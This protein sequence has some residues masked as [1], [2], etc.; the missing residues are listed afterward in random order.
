MY[1]AFRPLSKQVTVMERMNGKQLKEMLESGCNNLNNR[2]KEV[3]ALNVFPVPDGDTGTNMS[4]TFSNGISEILKSGSEELPVIAKTLSRGL[5]MGARGNSGVITSQIFRGFYQA[6]KELSDLGADDFCA[7]MK[8]GAKM[9]YK[10]VMRPVEGTILTVVREATDAADAYMK[11]HPSAPI[12]EYM[13]VL[14]KEAQKSLDHTPEL[15]PVLKE[16]GCVDSGGAGLVAI[17]NGF[18]SY[19]KGEPVKEAAEGIGSE[20]AEKKTG[21][22]TEYILKLTDQGTHL[23]KE[24]K[25]RDKLNAL[26]DH[27]TVVVDGDVIKTRVSTL[28][29]GDALN[30]GQRYGEFVRIQIEPESDSMNESILESAAEAPAEEQEYGIITVC[31]GKGLEK[32]FK[33]YRADYVV[34]GGQT[35]NPSTEDFVQAISKVNARHIFILPNNS[36]IIMAAKQ[37]ADVTENKDIIVLETKTIPQGLA[38]CIQFNPAET[39]EVN[40]ANMKEGISEV[41]S[42]QVTYAIKNTTIEGREIHE[43][44]YMGIL[45][46]DIVLTSREKTDATC[47]L[48]DQMVDE[49]SEIVTIIQGQDATDEET[50]AVSEYIENTYEVDVEVQK[51][52]QPVYCF[53]IG[54]E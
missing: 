4:L 37:A 24:S 26:G 34:S 44:D 27:I 16:T 45:N 23:F 50:K 21:Y 46:K 43:G 39:P 19:L 12:E 30:L 14:C 31:A 22:R 52:E 28:N 17:F 48:I 40:T 47:R 10:A 1:R 9:A 18:L 7:A 3:D 6:I 29:P 36:N 2:K 49:D 11:E 8:N 20:T 51:G 53:I 42:G 33:D 38:A 25:F 54:V 5:L 41:K 15:L 13:E 35:M 32:L